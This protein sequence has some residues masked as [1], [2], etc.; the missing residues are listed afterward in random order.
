MLLLAA[1]GVAGASAPA[2]FPERTVLEPTP[3]RDRRGAQ[4][5]GAFPG[6][7]V[8]IADDASG[9]ATSVDVELAEPVT[10]HAR[11][12]RRKLGVFARV[13]LEV[14]PGATW[15]MV[16]APLEILS[17]DRD[18]A[19]V[20]IGGPHA[21]RPTLP[22]FDV[23][24]DLLVWAPPPE[25]VGWD[26][27]GPLAKDRDRVVGRP[28][29]WDGMRELESDGGARSPPLA[30]GAASHDGRRTASI[31]LETEAARARVEVV[32]HLEWVRRRGWTPR[33]GLRL[34]YPKVPD[35]TCGCFEPGRWVLLASPTRGSAT[36]AA[37]ASLRAIA[38]GAPLAS[39]PLGTA[40]IALRIERDEAF[41]AWTSPPDGKVGRDPKLALFGLVPVEA[42]AG[43]PAST[44]NAVVE[45][46]LAPPP[47]QATRRGLL[48]HAR[49]GSR[50]LGLDARAAPAADG[51]FHLVAPAN[52][53]FVDVS[54]E[55]PEDAPRWR[56]A[57]A[58][59][60]AGKVVIVTLKREPD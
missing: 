30:G 53:G 27:D 33:A 60:D 18:H 49:W 15:V 35:V 7:V 23:P 32:D 58:Q 44:V 11:A 3:L 31:L 16:G 43:A 36:L 55:A 57:H 2:C 48:V 56:P 17:G 26:V 1:A 29:S 34:R 19:R 39:L 51:S 14:Q 9:D 50:D 46:K 5:G 40:V 21:A 47:D 52:R 54:V 8:R 22:P 45:G 38:G 20:E 42:L 13:E 24:C 10:V 4:I 28:V 6:Q 37:P 41:V 25:I 59:V 12:D